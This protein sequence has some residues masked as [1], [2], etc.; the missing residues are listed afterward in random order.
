[1]NTTSIS[2]APAHNQP[3]LSKGQKAFNALIKQIE[4]RRATLTEWE[5]FGPA[6]QQK[7][8]DQ[9]LPLIQQMNDLR[10]KM[11]YRFDEVAERKSITQSEQRTLSKLI[12]ELTGRCL[13]DSDDEAIKALHNKHSGFDYDTERAEEFEDMQMMLESMLGGNSADLDLSSPEQVLDLL[14]ERMGGDADATLAS[15]RHARTAQPDAKKTSRKQAAAEA[16][17]EEEEAQLSRSIR[18]VY[19]KLASA[20]HPDR[21]TDPQERE[22]KTAL[23]QQANEAYS[24]NNLLR[25]LELQLELEHIDQHALGNLS[26]ERLKHYNKILK[27]QVRELDDE[28]RFVEMEFKERYGLNPFARSTPKTAMRDLTREIVDIQYRIASMERDFRTFESVTVLRAW[29]RDVER[30]GRAF[31]LSGGEPY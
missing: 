10:L 26:E 19:R 18:E 5:A 1:M 31:S 20:L 4:K 28:I 11:A 13:A 3:A 22:R 24:K 30:Q 16:R 23:M 29:L 14:Y 12:E 21:E 6:F 25:L 2:I 17:R 15:A 9:L 7:Y 27:E 8:V